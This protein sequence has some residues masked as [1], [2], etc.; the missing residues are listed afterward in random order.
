MFSTPNKA[1]EEIPIISITNGVHSPSWLAAEISKLFKKQSDGSGLLPS[2]YT[3]QFWK[4][5]NNLSDEAVLEYS[6]S[7]E[8]SAYFAPYM[9]VHS[10]D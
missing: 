10:N 1:V 8:K 9:T 7:N 6:S 4:Y 3:E 5:A 2:E